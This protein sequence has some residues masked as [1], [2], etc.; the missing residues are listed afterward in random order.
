MAKS[1]PFLF[2]CGDKVKIIQNTSGSSNSVGDIGTI[3]NNPTK[4]STS[5]RVEVEGKS[6][7]SNWHDPVDLELYNGEPQ[8]EIY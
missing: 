7:S 8:Y 4:S 1:K 3:V 5:C 2:E 6:T